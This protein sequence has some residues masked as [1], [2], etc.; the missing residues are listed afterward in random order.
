MA[1]QAGKT[2]QITNT[3][4]SDR[5]VDLSDN[6][7]NPG[8]PLIGFHWHGGDNQQASLLGR[9]KQLSTDTQLSGPS[10]L[11]RDLRSLLSPASAYLLAPTRPRLLK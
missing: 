2:Y 6:V 11:V 7:T 3:A 4:F 9:Q 8:N 10:E 5:V 1:P